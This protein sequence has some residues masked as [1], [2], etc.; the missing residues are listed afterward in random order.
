MPEEQISLCLL[1]VRLFWL[2]SSK[3]EQA[4]TSAHDTQYV[5]LLVQT[6]LFLLAL[7]GLSG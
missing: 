4:L 6:E 7:K 1:V 5:C 2:V 3:E